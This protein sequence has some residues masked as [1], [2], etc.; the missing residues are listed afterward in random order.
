MATLINENVQLGLV[1]SF[2]DLVHCLRDEK[3]GI[4]QAD[5]TLEKELRF[6][7]S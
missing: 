6:F 2:R 5:I 1:Y 3:H 4:I 7:T